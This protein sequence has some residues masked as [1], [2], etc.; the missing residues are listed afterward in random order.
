MVGDLSS[1]GWRDALVN[2]HLV[3]DFTKHRVEI[4]IHH[5]QLVLVRGEMGGMHAHILCK[6]A[7][8]DTRRCKK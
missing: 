8:M 5:A 7:T 1:S 4:Q 6:R 3:G 2:G